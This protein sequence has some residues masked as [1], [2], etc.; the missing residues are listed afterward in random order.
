MNPARYAKNR[1]RLLTSTT[2]IHGVREMA[3]APSCTLRTLWL[4]L[5]LSFS[6]TMA[7]Q[8]YHLTYHY[9]QE[10]VVVVIKTMSDENRNSNTTTRYELPLTLLLIPTI[11]LFNASPEANRALNESPFDIHTRYYIR[12]LVDSHF[13][14]HHDYNGTHG[15][16]QFDQY[17]ADNP[18]LTWHDVVSPFVAN[19][20]YWL[21]DA[22][23]FKSF[24]IVNR[25]VSSYMTYHFIKPVFDQ[26]TLSMADETKDI[27]LDAAIDF[28]PDVMKKS[29][30]DHGKTPVFCIT[31]YGLAAD[32]VRI[33]SGEFTET[34]FLASWHILRT[35]IDACRMLHE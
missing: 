8:I 32:M 9:F 13:Q 33:Q 31:S 20:S 11:D 21:G 23:D 18:H 30:S 3:A 5:L 15:R 4:L 10:P 26:S 35:A 34:C 19:V 25:T 2:T 1:L 17:L 29:T 14:V 6:G 24:S 16:L 27:L 7:Y 22:E 28:S 12:S